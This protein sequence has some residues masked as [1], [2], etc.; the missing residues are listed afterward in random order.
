VYFSVTNYVKIVWRIILGNNGREEGLM[1]T[2][3]LI[4]SLKMPRP[5]E[6]LIRHVQQFEG[7]VEVREVLE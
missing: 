5:L 1:K 6:L 7:I 3:M 4:N 2:L